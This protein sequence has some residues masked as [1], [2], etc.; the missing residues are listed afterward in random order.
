[1]QPF[2]KL[3]PLVGFRCS[4]SEVVGDFMTGIVDAIVDIMMRNT[5]IERVLVE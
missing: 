4:G 1:M 3:I 5:L 2:F